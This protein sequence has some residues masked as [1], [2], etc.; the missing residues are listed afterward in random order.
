MQLGGMRLRSFKFV[1]QRLGVRLRI[2]SLLLRCCELSCQLLVLL[3]CK[4]LRMDQY[5]GGRSRC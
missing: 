3:L 1:G 4:A 2:L 5:N